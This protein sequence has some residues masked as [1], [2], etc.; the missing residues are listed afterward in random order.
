MLICMTGPIPG[1]GNTRMKRD[2]TPATVA[3]S[4]VGDRVKYIG[5]LEASRKYL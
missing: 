2:K 1:A 3:L 5:I 4:L